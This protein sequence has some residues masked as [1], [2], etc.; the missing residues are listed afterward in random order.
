MIAEGFS[1]NKNLKLVSVNLECETQQ[2][3][4]YHVT[5]KEDISVFATSSVAPT[6]KE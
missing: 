1:F 6:Q 5:K 4:I 2:A 3:L